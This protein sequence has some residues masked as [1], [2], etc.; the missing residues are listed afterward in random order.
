MISMYHESFIHAYA[1]IMR[2]S[3][4]LGFLGAFM[5]VLFIKNLKVKPN[6]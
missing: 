5:A 1:I 2:I 6:E 4:G 3:A